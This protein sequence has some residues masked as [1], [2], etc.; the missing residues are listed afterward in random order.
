MQILRINIHYLKYNFR[1][2]HGFQLFLKIHV[3]GR[4]ESLENT[5][6]VAHKHI[7]PT[8]DPQYPHRRQVW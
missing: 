8:L 7:D 5:T 1:C 2:D 4:G 3:D 6:F